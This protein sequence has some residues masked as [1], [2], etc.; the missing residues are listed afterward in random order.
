MSLIECTPSRDDT[1]DLSQCESMVSDHNVHTSITNMYRV[2]QKK[3]D[4]F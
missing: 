1:S 2:G 4:H 3:P